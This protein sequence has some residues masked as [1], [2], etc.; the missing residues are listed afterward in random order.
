MAA[1]VWD[2]C[3]FAKPLDRYPANAPRLW[4]ARRGAALLCWGFPGAARCAGGLRWYPGFS[5]GFLKDDGV[6]GARFP[7]DA[8][9]R[10][11][12]AE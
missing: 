6:E 8:R 10:P 5:T 7:S 4:P 12:L 1:F 9:Q 3:R 11:Q 2:E